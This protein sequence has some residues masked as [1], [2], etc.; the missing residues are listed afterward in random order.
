MICAA[1]NSAYNTI[2]VAILDIQVLLF[3][4]FAELFQIQMRHINGETL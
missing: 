1:S 2:R 4:S 3:L